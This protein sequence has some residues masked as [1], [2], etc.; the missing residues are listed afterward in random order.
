VLAK[1]R[2]PE[3]VS[4]VQAALRFTL[5]G[6]ARNVATPAARP[7]MPVD[8]GSPVQFVSVPEVGVPRIGVTSVGDVAS[9]T[10]P[11]PVIAATVRAVPPA[12]TAT[13]LEPL[14]ES[15]G[16]RSK[17]AWIAANSERTVDDRSCAPV[18]GVPAA[19]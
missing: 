10:L 1:T 12:L 19:V 8:T 6:V 3:P 14:P 13:I 11:V 4:S 7:E 2:A 5:E 18:L 15:V 9:T 16:R 17:P